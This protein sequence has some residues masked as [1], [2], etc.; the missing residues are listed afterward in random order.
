M[1][2]SL[3]CSSNSPVEPT[4]LRWTLR[5]IYIAVFVVGIVGNLVVCSAVVRRKRMRTSNNLFTINLAFADLIVVGIYVP[6]QM[7]AF[8]NHHNWPLGNFVCLVAYIT[9]PLCL[10]SSVGSLLAI[11]CDRYRAIAHPLRPRLTLKNVKIIIFVIW[12]LSFIT[13]IPLLFVAGTTRHPNDGKLY[14]S[15]TWPADTPY[16]KTYWISIFIVQYVIPLVLIAVLSR[17]TAKKIKQND[18][19]KKRRY[20]QVVTNAVR[21]RMKQSTRITN[22]LIGL[23]VLYTVCMLP[24]HIVYF[25]MTYGNLNYLSYKM[26]IFR[27]AN[28]FPMANCALNPIVYGTLNKEFG[29][30]FKTFFAHLKCRNTSTNTNGTGEQPMDNLIDKKSAMSSLI[31]RQSTRIE[32]QRTRD[33]LCCDINDDLQEGQPLSQGIGQSL[34]DK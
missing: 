3:C 14:C 20:S 28:V 22:M 13:S 29:Q 23:V 10:S 4:P 25:W 30:V 12:V 27:L 7:A 26:Y 8:E 18:F 32:F 16:E 15:E 2:G 1:N 24:Q 5:L 33:T 9:I 11:T 6:T 17:V 19:F 34:T 21:Q 31:D